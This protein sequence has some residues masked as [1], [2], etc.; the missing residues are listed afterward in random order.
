MSLEHLS[1]LNNF[2]NPLMAT[3]HYHAVYY[4]LRLQVIDKFLVLAE[5]Y[6]YINGVVGSL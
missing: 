5:P 3:C 4:K 6:L 2:L 1:M